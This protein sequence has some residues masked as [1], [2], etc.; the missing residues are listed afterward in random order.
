MCV[1]KKKPVVGANAGKGWGRRSHYQS[2][3]CS[4]LPARSYKRTV[5]APM[6]VCVCMWHDALFMELGI[7]LTCLG[8]KNHR[9]WDPRTSIIEHRTRETHE[10]TNNDYEKK[11]EKKTVIYARIKDKKTKVRT[12]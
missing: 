6:R 5:C 2:F 12:W 8:G 7:C 1:F 10:P 11:R 4:S 9:T 3:T